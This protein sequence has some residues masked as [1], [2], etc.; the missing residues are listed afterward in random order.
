M[1]MENVT[2]LPTAAKSYFTVRNRRGW[3]AVTLVTPIPGKN[4]ETDV[5]LFD[6]RD[7]A[8]DA[9][10]SGAAKQARPFRLRGQP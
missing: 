2:K 7:Q 1:N 9:A 3:F 6:D 8:I 10:R 5:A 4:L